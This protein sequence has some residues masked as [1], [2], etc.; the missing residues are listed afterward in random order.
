M[1]PQVDLFSSMALGVWWAHQSGNSSSPSFQS[2]QFF[3]KD[4]IAFLISENSAWGFWCFL[5][6]FALPLFPFGLIFLVVF[7]SLT[8]EAS[9]KYLVTCGSLTISW[10]LSNF[11][12]A[13]KSC[14]LQGFCRLTGS[15]AL[16][17]L[18][19]SASLST[20]AMSLT[21]LL[22]LLALLLLICVF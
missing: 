4:V 3:C 20:E 1:C 18:S 2:S 9:F 12:D 21:A 16:A 14:D 11:S 13:S 19:W 7:I 5:L 15:P 6:L 17:R 22:R 8:S 10:G